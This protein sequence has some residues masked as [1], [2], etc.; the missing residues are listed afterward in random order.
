MQL[1]DTL[2]SIIGDIWKTLTDPVNWM[3][4]VT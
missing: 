4:K 2:V 3:S 1:V